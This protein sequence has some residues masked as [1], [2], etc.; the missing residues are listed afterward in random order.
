MKIYNLGTFYITFLSL[1]KIEKK[2]IF[3][4]LKE[5]N[6]LLSQRFSEEFKMLNCNIPNNPQQPPPTYN[7]NERKWIIVDFFLTIT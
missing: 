7:Q 5:D 6:N 3:N 1:K 4:F 2:K